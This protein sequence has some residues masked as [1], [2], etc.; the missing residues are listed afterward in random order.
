MVVSILTRSSD[1]MQLLPVR[2]MQRRVSI[3]TRSS[4]RMHP[5]LC[6][7]PSEFQSSPGRLTGC[8]PS[9]RVTPRWRRT[10]DVSILTRSSDRMQPF[11]WSGFDAAIR[12]DRVVSI[13]TRSSDR[14]Q[15]DRKVYVY[16]SRWCRHR[17]R[18]D[19]RLGRVSILTRSSDRMQLAFQCIPVDTSTADYMFQ[20]SPGRLT[21]CNFKW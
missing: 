21:G 15:L 14:M 7:L 9:A 11:S 1:R 5:A 17:M 18:Y 6:M 3:L 2:T 12:G 10:F 4:D 13:L 20:S 19:V 8:N 16:N